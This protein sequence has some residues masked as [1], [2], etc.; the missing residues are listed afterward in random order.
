MELGAFAVKLT[1]G[2]R[3]RNSFQNAVW[4]QFPDSSTTS[5]QATIAGEGMP[6]GLLGATG[7]DPENPLLGFW[8][9]TG[10]LDANLS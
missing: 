10:R 3:R 1:G 8:E 4:E 7:N 5:K 2:R 9:S 6:I